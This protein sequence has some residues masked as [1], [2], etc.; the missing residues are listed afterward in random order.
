[1]KGGRPDYDA[2]LM[3]KIMV[4]Q[5]LYSL[6]DDQ[7]EFR[8]QDRL[9]FLGFLRLWLGDRVPDAKKI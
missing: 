9:S 7:V 6:S 1:M 8:V 2:V 5:V 3:F 4:L